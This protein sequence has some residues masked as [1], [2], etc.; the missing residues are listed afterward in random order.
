MYTIEYYARGFG[1]KGRKPACTCGTSADNINAPLPAHDG[2]KSL[3]FS[4]SFN[5]RL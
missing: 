2:I 1:I 3:Q 5:K 4:F